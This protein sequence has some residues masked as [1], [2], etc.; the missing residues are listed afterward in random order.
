MGDITRMIDRS[1]SAAHWSPEDALTEALRLVQSGDCGFTGKKL[2]I[3]SL[4]DSGDG[5][6]TSYLQAGMKKSECVALC[7]IAASDF[8]KKMDGE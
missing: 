1:G 6:E 3:L 5:Y 7:Q 8:I 2:L 4:D